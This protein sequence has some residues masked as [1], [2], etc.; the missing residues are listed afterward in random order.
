MVTVQGTELSKS[1]VKCKALEIGVNDGKSL[2]LWQ[3]L[4]PNHNLIVGIGY[5]VGKEVKKDTFK[6]NLSPRQ[7]LTRVPHISS[8]QSHNVTKST[9]QVMLKSA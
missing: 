7:G 6:R 2:R 8:Q 3:R 5:G 9:T 4:F 1:G